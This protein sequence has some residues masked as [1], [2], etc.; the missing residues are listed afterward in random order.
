MD[1]T[2]QQTQDPARRAVELTR[3]GTGRYT[4][5]NAAGAEIAFGTGEDLLSPVE[6]LLAA[7]AGCS[8]VGV[9]TATSR[10]AQPTRFRVAATGHEVVEEGARRLDGLHLSFD[11]AFP[12][13]DGGRKAAGLVERL[14]ALAH[15]KHC[16]V[17]RT[18]EHGAPVGHDVAVA[19]EDP[20]GR[21]P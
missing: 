7:L 10:S 4:A 11:L 9:D 12:D 15:D 21:E 8:S 20:A 13:D 16:T 5:R 3:T 17:S 18:I 1:P 2:A 6:L 19:L 14:I